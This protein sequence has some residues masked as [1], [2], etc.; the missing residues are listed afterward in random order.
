MG[1]QQQVP[2]FKNRRQPLGDRP[3]WHIVKGPEESRVILPRLVGQEHCAGSGREG[4][5]GLVEADVA[6]GAFR[7]R[8]CRSIPP[9]ARISA[10]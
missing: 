9:A 3:R 4:R 6:I 8:I 7:P 2:C 1:D 5:A 10:S